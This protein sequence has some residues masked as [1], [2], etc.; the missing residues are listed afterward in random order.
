MIQKAFTIKIYDNDGTTFIRGLKPSEVKEIPSFTSQ[1]NGGFGQCALNLNLPFD[2]FG[3][4]SEIN[5]MNIVKIYVTDENNTLG[6]LV[7]T[8]F[9][10]AFMPYLEGA[11]QGVKVTLLGLVSLLSLAYYKDGADFTVAHSG[12]DPAVIM[13]AIVDHFNSVYSGSLLGYDSGGTTVDTVGTNVAYTFVEDTWIDAMKGAFGTV[14]AGWWWTVDKQGQL[15]LKEKPA[16]ATHRFTIGK[17]IESIEV[18]KS[19]EKVINQVRVKYGVNTVD[20]SDAGS[21]TTFGVRERIVTDDKIQDATTATQRGD[22]EVDDNKVEKIKARMII[23][24]NYDLETIKVGD[25]CKIQNLA[26]DQTT[27]N[28]NMMIVSVNYSFDKVS[29]E[30]EEQTKFSIEL[31]KFIS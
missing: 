23:N 5:F 29:I 19:S 11:D 10:S 20:V 25:T 9:I 24:S 6:R 14:G 8:G 7:Y 21:I 13:K 15:Y 27:F 3:E 22:Q 17:D 4:G 26:V 28:D 18:N 1:I 12:V 30:L 31:Q 16:T 2:D